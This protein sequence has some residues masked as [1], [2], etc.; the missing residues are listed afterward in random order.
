MRILVLSTAVAAL[1]A[2]GPTGPKTAEGATPCQQLRECTC[3]PERT[4]DVDGCNQTIDTLEAGTDPD[5]TCATYLRI[6]D[7][8]N[9]LQVDTTRISL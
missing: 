7:C 9:P 6:F 5:R 4:S 2:C 8:G 3:D 1:L